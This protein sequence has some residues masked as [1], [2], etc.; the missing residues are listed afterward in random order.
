VLWGEFSSTRPEKATVFAEQPP[1]QLTLLRWSF[2]TETV[3]DRKRS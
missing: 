2:N 3:F 1:A